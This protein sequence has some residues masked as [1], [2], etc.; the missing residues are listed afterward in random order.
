MQR[1]YAYVRDVFSPLTRS[2]NSAHAGHVLSSR[3]GGTLDLETQSGYKFGLAVLV[4]VGAA[5]VAMPIGATAALVIVAVVMASRALTVLA[6]DPEAARRLRP[7]ELA[8]WDGALAAALA[9]IAL[10]LVGAG[11]A[12]GAVVAVAGAVTLAALRL[13]TRYVTR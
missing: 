6:A 8:T 7:R 4:G 11:A 9:L 2:S 12:G 3:R 10:V 5:A 13:R 1:S